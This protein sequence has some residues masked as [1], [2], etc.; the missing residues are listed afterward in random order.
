MRRNPSIWLSLLG[1][2]A[3][4]TTAPVHVANAQLTTPG[5]TERAGGAETGGLSDRIATTAPPVAAIGYNLPTI[6]YG[7]PMPPPSLT[8]S[9][10]VAAAA[11][12]IPGFETVTATASIGGRSANNE[13]IVVRGRAGIDNAPIREDARRLL[14]MHVDK[15]QLDE[16]SVYFF[17]PVVATQWLN[18]KPALPENIQPV[19]EDNDDDGPDCDGPAAIAANPA[20][21]AQVGAERTQEAIEAELERFQERAQDHWDDATEE[22][23]DVWDEALNCFSDHVLP[24]GTVPVRFDITPTMTV[25]LSQ[26]GARGSASGTLSGSVGLGIPMEADLQA[27]VDFFYIPCLPFVVRPRSITVTGDLTVGEQLTIDARATGEFEKTYTIPPSGGPRIP[28]QV[29][30]VII[31]G[32][33]VAVIDISAYIEGEVTVAGNGDVTGNLTLSNEHLTTFDFTC[34][35]NGCRTGNRGVPTASTPV[36]TTQ[37][38]TIQGEVSAKPGIYTALMVTLN[39]NVLGARLGPQP[40]LLGTAMGCGNATATQTNGG[41]ST[42]EQ[43]AAFIADLDWG[44]D[45]RAEA[46]VGGK[47]VENGTYRDSII[48]PRHVWFRDLVPGGSSA[49]RA[50]LAGPSAAATG[51]P[52]VYRLRMPSCY[53]YAEDTTYRVSWTGAPQPSAVPESACSWD[54]ANSSGRCEFDPARELE[55]RFAWPT[56][57]DYSLAAVLVGDDHQNFDPQP[58][59]TELVVA[60]TGEAVTSSES[61]AAGRVAGAT[62]VA[63][64]G[65]AA[66]GADS[67]CCDIV[68]NPDMRGRLGRVVVAYPEEVDA[69]IDVFRPGETQAA[70]SDYGDAAFDLLPGTYDVVIS[71]KRVTGV[72]VRSG[73]DTRIRVGVLRVSA[74]DSTRIDL[75]EGADRRS[76]TS[77]YGPSTFGLPIGE[78]GV[79]I[80]GQT[81]TVT[82][83]AGQVTEF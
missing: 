35:G 13:L 71:G 14:A 59:A 51:Q 18:S 19:E 36:T 39:G 33:P 76:L 1:L 63:A 15:L 46:L 28:I 22:L 42:G 75:V 65:R 64:A 74:S 3:S 32:V 61:G 26:S 37:E 79:Q 81:E 67:G 77:N 21:C 82:V 12:Q 10:E 83:V 27:K 4:A 78:V 16:S 52:A 70:A 20:E 38:V 48:D 30:P 25:S 24:G 31:G 58:P 55:L 80:A 49:L 7:E 41:N 17:D 23:A 45:F 69:R 2:A 5:R 56:A 47:V 11:V 29:I 6:S 54:A 57:G 72:T 34:G 44:V 68:P 50:A 66:T 8:E 9:L 43:N 53:P 73:N 60:V 62:T 40:Y